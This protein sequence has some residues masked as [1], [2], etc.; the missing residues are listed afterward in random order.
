[1]ALKKEKLKWHIANRSRHCHFA[2]YHKM[3]NHV[4]KTDLYNS[5]KVWQAQLQSI[6][7][8]AIE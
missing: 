2:A 8:L 5:C 7:S 4:E 6:V 1:M 3:F